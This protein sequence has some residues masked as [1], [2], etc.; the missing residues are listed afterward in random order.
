MDAGDVRRVRLKQGRCVR[1]TAPCVIVLP[2]DCRLRSVTLDAI[3]LEDGDIE[4]ITLK[5]DDPRKPR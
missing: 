2:E 3:M 4:S 5:G 1:I